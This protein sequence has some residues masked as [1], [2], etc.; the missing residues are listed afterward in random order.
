MGHLMSSILLS[1]LLTSSVIYPKKSDDILT[2]PGIGFT[3]LQ[4]IVSNE[5]TNPFYG[6]KPVLSYPDTSTVYYRWYWDQLTT[7]DNPNLNEAML[8][9]KIDNVLKDAASVNKKVVIRFMALRGKGDPIY[10]VDVNKDSSGIPCWLV[11]ELYGH[12][13]NGT[14]CHLSDEEAV[15]MF[16][17]PQFI[18][19][20]Q[21]F[22][23]T[24]GQRYD[25]NKTLLRIDVGMVGTWG[26]WNLS[27]YS[28]KSSLSVGMSDNGYKVQD[29]K[30]YID[31]IIKAFPHTP[32]V[33]L[34]TNKGDYLSYATQKGFGW[35][36]DCLG[37][38]NKG[39]N[40][41]EDG[42]PTMILHMTDASTNKYPDMLFNQRW[43]KSA[44]DFEI[45][46]GSLQDWYSIKNTH[47]LTY[48]QVL[49]TFDFALKQHA[50]LINAK[51]GVIPK[52]YQL[53][54][55][56]FLNKLGYRYQ[57]NQLKVNNVVHQND[58]LYIDSTWENVGVAPIYSNYPVTW[59]L[60]S[61]NGNIVAYYTSTA[62]IVNWLPADNENVKNPIYV[63]TDKFK[64]NN[65]SIGEYFL[66]VGLVEKHTRKAKISLAI[67]TKLTDDNGKDYV[68]EMNKKQ[69]NMNNSQQYIEDQ[70]NIGRWREITI[71]NII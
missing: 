24:L 21:E 49:K 57:L 41:M 14:S 6:D 19:R 20:S 52:R 66:D 16:K 58:Y 34:G 71:I 48:N 62:N 67:D 12:G 45:C 64:I 47:R 61:A 23:S 63:I 7:A 69:F 15:N 39:W 46:Q 35:R 25:H 42:Y 26:E 36:V 29:L 4:R 11:D 60:R 31:A 3:E 38:W 30:P 27:G 55:K 1:L 32:K 33:M 13:L 54:V 2:N 44:V 59:R 43:K 56:Q 8:E 65:I 40:H 53:L 51:S 28:S 70:N 18:H 5:P 37:D 9:R 10:D 22:L 50:S 17:I 68:I